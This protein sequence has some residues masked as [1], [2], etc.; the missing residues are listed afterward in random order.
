MVHSCV[1]AGV[2]GQGILYIT[3]IMHDAAVLEGR[4]VMASETHGMAQRGGSVVSHLR[5]DQGSSPL[6][7]KGT[8][9]LLLVFEPEEVFGTLSFL[10]RAGDLVV[11]A[12]SSQ[13]LGAVGDYLKGRGDR[14]HALNAAAMAEDMG[15]PL[16]GNLILLGFAVGRVSF[17]FSLQA[18]RT[19]I[20]HTTRPSLR[21]SNLNALERGFKAGLNLRLDSEMD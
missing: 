1:L 12:S 13:Y 5:M 18:I 10:K 20:E 14:I 19:A 8:A 2:G 9:D 3:R 4:R 6:V 15:N 21:E 16:A 11:N 17:P 7:R